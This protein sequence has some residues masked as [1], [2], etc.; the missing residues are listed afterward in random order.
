MSEPG[1][2]ERSREP[3]Q[4]CGG[5]RRCAGP[6]L[7]VWGVT[8]L[9]YGNSQERENVK[10]E[11]SQSRVHG[12][13]TLLVYVPGLTRGGSATCLG[14]C[15]ISGL[16]QEGDGRHAPPI[17]RCSKWDPQTSSSSSSWDSS[18]MAH[19]LNRRLVLTRSTGICTYTA[20]GEGLL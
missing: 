1:G 6:H 15:R 11:K 18:P 17:P 5:T 20:A 13:E 10:A 2:G 3:T 4:L 14:V 7:Q 12:A 9:I 16:P 8:L 19:P